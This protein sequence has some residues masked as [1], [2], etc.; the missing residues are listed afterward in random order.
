MCQTNWDVSHIHCFSSKI[1]CVQVVFLILLPWLCFFPSMQNSSY[2]CCTRT[3][4]N[5]IL[6]HSSCCSTSTSFHVIL[7]SLCCNNGDCVTRQVLCFSGMLNWLHNLYYILMY[8]YMLHTHLYESIATFIV[9]LI[10][11]KH[12]NSEQLLEGLPVPYWSALMD[13][14]CSWG[15]WNAASS[16]DGFTL[17]LR[18]MKR[19]Q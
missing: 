7:V 18:C 3:H 6:P 17:L 10:K 4:P 13:L 19:C 9:F 11:I 5:A 14:H 12:R 2:V 15:V 1:R 8:I 16:I